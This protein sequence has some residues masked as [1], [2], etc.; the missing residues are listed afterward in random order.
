MV[1]S[2][3]LAA[4]IQ[5]SSVCQWVCFIDLISAMQTHGPGSVKGHLSHQ[6]S[7]QVCFHPDQASCR[8]QYW[9]RSSLICVTHFNTFHG[10]TQGNIHPLYTGNHSDDTFLL[11]SK[12]L[13]NLHLEFLLGW[14]CCF[15]GGIVQLLSD[16]K[17]CV[18][19]K[20]CVSSNREMIFDWITLLSMFTGTRTLE[21]PAFQLK[22]YSVPHHL[23]GECLTQDNGLCL[24]PACSISISSCFFDCEKIAS[25]LRPAQSCMD[26]CGF[27]GKA[28][29]LSSLFPRPKSDD[30]EGPAGW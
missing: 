14:Q 9:S 5:V 11:Q 24:W 7:D 29:A 13:E 17:L 6:E 2:L 3:N 10:A 16:V 22:K 15:I 1:L 28:N 30:P 23:P 19:E 4:V 20:T 18:K 27:W 8:T 26:L 21:R 12:T 25:A